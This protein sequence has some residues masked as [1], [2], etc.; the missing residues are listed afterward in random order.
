MH[1]GLP[2]PGGLQGLEPRCSRASPVRIA[3]VDVG[4][5]VK[6]GR[7]KDTHLLGRDHGDQGRR[8]ADPQGRHD[9]D[10]PAPVPRGQLLPRARSRARRTRAEMPDGGIMPVSQ[11]ATPV[12][13][14]QV[15][16]SLQSDTRSVLQDTI[17]GLGTAF[18]YEAHRRGRRRAGSRRA[19]P[20]RRRR[21][22]TRRSRRA[23]ARCAT[24]R[25]S[26]DALLGDDPHDLSRADRAA[27]RAPAPGSASTSRRCATS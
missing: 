7:Y 20:D 4:K 8:P 17:R 13:L 2:H 5:V 26:N 12:Q 22:S 9:Q 21:P 1:A 16:T 3:G 23:W 19:R 10:P 25:S 24:R 6:V 14:D 11:T 15:L 18:S 27:S